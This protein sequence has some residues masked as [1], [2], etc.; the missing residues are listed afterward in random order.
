[1]DATTPPDRRAQNSARLRAAILGACRELMAKGNF[2]PGAAEVAALAGCSTRTVFNY[3]EDTEAVHHAAITDGAT[4]EAIFSAIT[5]AARPMESMVEYV[6]AA[7]VFGR[8]LSP[9]PAE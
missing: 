1:M 8:A 3:F 7:A 5:S 9:Q 6:V 4:R 2:R